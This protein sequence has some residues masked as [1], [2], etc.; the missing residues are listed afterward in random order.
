MLLKN[1]LC[2]LGICSSMFLAACNDS[3]S[4]KTSSNSTTQKTL[5]PIV[6][7]GALPV[8]S[9]QMASKLRQFYS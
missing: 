4:D 1:F 9:E 8:E 5:Q 3:D 2:A 6:I 7:Q